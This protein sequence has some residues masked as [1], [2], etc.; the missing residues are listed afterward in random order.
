MKSPAKKLDAIPED[1]PKTEPFEAD[2]IQRIFA[3]LPG[4]EDEYGRKA[5]AIAKQMEAFVGVMYTTW[6]SG[7]DNLEKFAKELSAVEK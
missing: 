2:E 7:Y 1:R 6:C 3:A 4:L 5:E